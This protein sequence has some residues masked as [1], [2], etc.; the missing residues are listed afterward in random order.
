MSCSPSVLHQKPERRPTLRRLAE[1]VD[2]GLLLAEDAALM[3][4]QPIA[5]AVAITPALID[6]MDPHD[7]HDPIRQQFIP[8]P[9]EYVTEI[10]EYEDPIGDHAHQKT[11]GLIHRYPDR[12]LLKVVGTCPVYCR[13][14]FRREMVGPDKGTALTPQQIEAA[15]SY[16][17]ATPAVREV[18][19]TGGDPLIMA[20]KRLEKLARRLGQISHIETIRWHSRLPVASPHLVTPILAAALAASGKPTRL[21]LHINHP[22]EF[23]LATR[24]AITCLQQHGLTLI[25]QSVLLAGIN[26]DLDVLQ[27]LKTYFDETGLIPYYMHHPDLAKGTGHFRFPL[28]KGI[29]LMR[30]WHQTSAS[31]VLPRYVLDLP[32]GFG[33]IDLLSNAVRRLDEHHYLVTD[34]TGRQ[35]PYP[36][37][38]SSPA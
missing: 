35:H 25:S 11:P 15:L 38:S 23:S 6:L 8:D 16:I 31:A 24:A 34:R 21:A 19:I 13:F 10:N 9:R 14:C 20:P 12:V 3:D 29:A 26:T 18:I 32:G 2:A 33:K 5:Y 28:S 36:P 4:Q 22:R 30:A 7:P 1:L 17:D 27:Q 37:V